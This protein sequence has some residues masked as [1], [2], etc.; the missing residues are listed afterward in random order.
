MIYSSTFLKFNLGAMY[1]KG[2]GNPKDTKK[3]LKY[4]KHASSLGN[5]DAQMKTGW[6]YYHIIKNPIQANRYFSMAI[7]QADVSAHSYL[8][9]EFYLGCIYLKGDG[10][11]KDLKRTLSHLKRADD[12][13]DLE[14][15]IKRAARMTS[16]PHASL[17]EML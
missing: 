4:F 12:K 1:I 7:K 2:I 9:S 3:A 11:E 10:V 17:E 14:S 8:N 15:L 5:P 13:E 6:I 16:L